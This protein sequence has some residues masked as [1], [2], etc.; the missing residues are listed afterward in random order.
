MQHAADGVNTA[1][2]GASAETHR[3]KEVVGSLADFAVNDIR[4]LSSDHAQNLADA[5]EGLAQLGAKG[6]HIVPRILARRLRLVVHE[7]S[8]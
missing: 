7:T 5:A 3:G 6:P 8:L 4:C 1:C 2:D